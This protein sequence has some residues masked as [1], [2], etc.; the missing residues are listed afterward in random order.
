MSNTTAVV[1]IGGENLSRNYE[2][3]NFLAWVALKMQR[4]FSLILQFM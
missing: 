4:F 1:E 3:C 2:G